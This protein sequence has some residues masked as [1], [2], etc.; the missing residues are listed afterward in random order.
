MKRVAALTF[1]VVATVAPAAAEDASCF[2]DWSDAARIAAR[3]R[4]APVEA[5]TA[6]TRER[7]LGSIVRATLCSHQ[8]RFIY[9]LVVR[10]HTGS[11]M[12]ITVDAAR[13]FGG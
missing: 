12:S 7:R 6:L 1:L 13:P 8:G 10:S 3:E 2:A 9:R 5:L 11:L 4:L